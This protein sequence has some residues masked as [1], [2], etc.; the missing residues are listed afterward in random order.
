M[1]GMGGQ[2]AWAEGARAAQTLLYTLARGWSPCL[3]LYPERGDGSTLSPRDQIRSGLR[4]GSI[5]YYLCDSE[6]VT[7]PLS[8]SIS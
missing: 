4:V 5:T 3:A 1:S 6:Q 8:T 2:S 7:P